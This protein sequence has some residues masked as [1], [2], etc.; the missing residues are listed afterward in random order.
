MTA[1][2]TKNV[3]FSSW[4]NFTT[5]ATVSLVSAAVLGVICLGAAFFLNHQQWIPQTVYLVGIVSGSTMLGGAA[6][7][8][9]VVL[10]KKPPPNLQVLAD[11]ETPK[12]ETPKVETPHASPA[13]YGSTLAVDVSDIIETPNGYTF[14][15]EL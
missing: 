13:S 9:M 8:F 1:S 14:E 7:A 5:A 12:V 15:D 4:E 6:I 3:H 2:T 10:C 11:P